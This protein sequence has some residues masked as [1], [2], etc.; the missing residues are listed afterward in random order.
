MTLNGVPIGS[1]P[2]N[3]LARIEVEVVDT[4]DT[5]VITGSDATSASGLAGLQI[6]PIA[7]GAL[8]LEID[9][10]GDGTFETTERSSWTGLGF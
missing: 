10:D 6:V 9:A 2:P 8:N 5:L 4:G 7:S 1:I 3:S